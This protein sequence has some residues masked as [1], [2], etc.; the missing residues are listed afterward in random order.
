MKLQ[1]SNSDSVYEVF[2]FQMFIY[3]EELQNLVKLLFLTKTTV[4]V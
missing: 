4:A 2:T 3:L 1:Q